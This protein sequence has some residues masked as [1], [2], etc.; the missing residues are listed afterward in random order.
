MA[1]LELKSP[2]HSK[3]SARECHTAHTLPA[4]WERTVVLF[5]GNDQSRR[6]SDVHLFHGGSLMATAT[7]DNYGD[8]KF[9]RLA[10]DSGA[11]VV[12][13][14]TESGMKRVEANVTQSV[15]LGEIRI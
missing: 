12:S 3:P 8:F 10:P 2:A 11:Y 1:W 15:S 14:T 7:T 13:I 4:P 9:D 6:F 5:G